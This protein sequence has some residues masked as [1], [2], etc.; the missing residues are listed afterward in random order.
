MKKSAAEK[1][2]ARAA[3][4]RAA[5]SEYAAAIERGETVR[6]SISRGNSKMGDIPSVSLLPLITCPACCRD[7]CA[8]DCY[9]AKLAALRPNVL[10]AWARNTAFAYYA[11][12]EYWTAVNKAIAKARF[13][14]FHVSGDTVSG[15]YLAHVVDAARN[16]P[17]CDILMFTKAFRTV[18]G[19]ID[20]H[21]PLPD[22]LHV[23]F[24]GWTNLQPENPHNLPETTVYGRKESPAPEWIPCGGNCAECAINGRGCWTAKSGDTIAFRMH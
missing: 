15:S 7:T 9:A 12:A 5:V 4:F 16:N 6:A 2:A 19:W 14:R 20:A 22:N 17:G 10:R 23:L 8:G 24:S 3:M 1:N 18:N 21:G 13:F 11:P